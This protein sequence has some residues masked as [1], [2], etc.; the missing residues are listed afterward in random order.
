MKARFWVDNTNVVIV[1]QVL[2]NLMPWCPTPFDLSVKDGNTNHDWQ[3]AAAGYLTALQ[4]HRF[5]VFH[6]YI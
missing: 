6:A 3:T 1:I 5:I 4:S 2:Y